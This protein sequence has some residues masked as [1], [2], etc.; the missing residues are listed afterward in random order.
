MN[1]VEVSNLVKLYGLTSNI[2]TTALD[3][4]SFVVEKGEF[5]GIMGPSG[6]G[7]TTLLNML[8]GID[9]ITS[10]NVTISGTNINKMKTNELALFRRHKMGFI[11]QDF[12]LLDSLTIKENIILPLVLDKK[13]SQEI[14]KKFDELTKMVDIYEIKDKYPNSI[15][16]GQKQRTAF[17][18]A[19]INDPAIIFADEPT[20]NLDSKSS[21]SIMGHFEK[22]NSY[23]K[24]TILMVTHDP[25]AASYCNKIIFIKD[26]KI[27]ME[28]VKKGIRKAFFDQ[29]LDCL[30]VIGGEKNEI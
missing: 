2:Q 9:K 1:V 16:G 12:N 15:S 11:F 19:L 10:G 27:N 30:C 21:K 28:I 23:R 3:D 13:N 6:S 24:S 4:V 20:G 18:R 22:I 7:K 26:G 29:I 8:S 25:F 14:N 5:T 17:C